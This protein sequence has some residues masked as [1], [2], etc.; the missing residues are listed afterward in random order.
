MVWRL[1][2]ILARK[3][4]STQPEVATYLDSRPLSSSQV[5]VWLCRDM[6]AGFII[7]CASLLV[8]C[9]SPEQINIAI[10]QNLPWPRLT[11][12]I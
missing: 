9:L 12:Q 7:G 4:E 11:I 10:S 1:N 8:F 6:E 5:E 2:K 3:K